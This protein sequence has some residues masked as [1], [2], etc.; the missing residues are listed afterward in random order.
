MNPENEAYE[1][2]TEGEAMPLEAPVEAVPA[3]QAPKQA[4]R[5]VA[6]AQAPVAPAIVEDRYTAYLSEEVKGVVDRE[7]NKLFPDL[8]SQMAELLNRVDIIDK[9]TG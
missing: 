3:Q 4:A 7:T 5:N 9:K 6:P 2:L 8:D 1:D